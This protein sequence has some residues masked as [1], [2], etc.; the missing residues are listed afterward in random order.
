[1]K[2]RGEFSTEQVLGFIL[3]VA[4]VFLLMLLLFRII[5][6]FNEED[7]MA[8]ATFD[9][10]LVAIEEAEAGHSGELYLPFERE[11][12]AYFL[13]YF[14]DGQIVADWL[15]DSA[16]F[17]DVFRTILD[18]NFVPQVD[19]RY[20]FFSKKRGKNLICVCSGRVPVNENDIGTRV[21]IQKS[22][23]VKFA[24]NIEA[25]CDNCVDVKESVEFMVG[26]GKVIALEQGVSLK[27]AKGANGYVFEE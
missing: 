27:I 12:F 18:L 4:V 13:V 5:A 23:V 25:S 15:H 16:T 3:A 6:S 19:I 14:A 9:R 20:D 21:D 11:G 26:D 8:K 7:E 10:L 24:D 17:A 2:K 22:K 1:M